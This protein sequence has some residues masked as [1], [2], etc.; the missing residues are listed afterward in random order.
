MQVAWQVVPPDVYRAE[1][2]YIVLVNHWLWAVE[3]RVG[4]GYKISGTTRKSTDYPL[5][6]VVSS[7]RH[8][9]QS[10]AKPVR[11]EERGMELTPKVAIIVFSPQLCSELPIEI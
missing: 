5:K 10:S 1:L 6:R 8:H 11:G 2:S 7:A 3:R 4:E 9:Q